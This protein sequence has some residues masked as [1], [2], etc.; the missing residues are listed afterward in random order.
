MKPYVTLIHSSQNNML[1]YFTIHVTIW[2]VKTLVL[3]C[4]SQ[5]YKKVLFIKSLILA[6]GEIMPQTKSEDEM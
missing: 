3:I 1:L 4:A 5:N 2:H 6:A